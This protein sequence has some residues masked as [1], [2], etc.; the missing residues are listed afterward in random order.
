M[1]LVLKGIRTASDAG[2]SIGV[3]DGASLGT[4]EG[5][6][7]SRSVQAGEGRISQQPILIHAFDSGAEGKPH[8]LVQTESLDTNGKRAHLVGSI[9]GNEFSVGTMHGRGFEGNGIGV[10]LFH[11]LGEYLKENHPEVKSVFGL[12]GGT[13]DNPEGIKRVPNSF[14]DTRWDGN[15]HSTPVESLAR[16]PGA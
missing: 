15:F 13:K 2:V 12:A 4:V 10:D 11:A 14:D 16:G 5:Q 3:T 6:P 9:K 1:A 7:V 8:I